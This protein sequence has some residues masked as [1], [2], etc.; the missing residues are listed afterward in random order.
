M[1]LE[2]E[3]K[4]VKAVRD[5]VSGKNALRLV[6]FLDVLLDWLETLYKDRRL[7]DE[8]KIFSSFPVQTLMFLERKN[9]AVSEDEYKVIKKKLLEESSQLVENVINTAEIRMVDFDL[10]QFNTAAIFRKEEITTMVEWARKHLGDIILRR[11]DEEVV[12]KRRKKEEQEAYFRKIRSMPDVELRRIV[13]KS[14]FDFSPKA[15]THKERISAIRNNREKM[16]KQKER[17]RRFERKLIDASVDAKKDAQTRMSRKVTQIRAKVEEKVVE[18]KKKSA[19]IVSEKGV[20]VKI[21]EARA[22]VLAEKK[23][24]EKNIMRVE[25]EWNTAQRSILREKEHITELISTKGKTWKDDFRKETEDAQKH[26]GLMRTHLVAEQEKVQKLIASRGS[27]ELGKAKDMVVGGKMRFERDVKKAQ[28]R[29]SGIAEKMSVARIDF[30]EKRGIAEQGFRKK[31]EVMESKIYDEMYK[32][33]RRFEKERDKVR[34]LFTEK[35]GEISSAAEEYI[36]E[37]KRKFTMDVESASK[38][39]LARAGEIGQYSWSGEGSRQLG[40][41]GTKAKEKIS[42]AHIR[43]TN[44]AISERDK[45]KKEIVRRKELFLL[46]VR[47]A[48]DKI[49]RQAREFADRIAEKREEFQERQQQVVARHKAHRKAMMIRNLLRTIRNIK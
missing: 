2:K 46:D 36:S 35:A 32:G 18:F 31:G 9:K 43:L 15:R 5:R 19:E 22:R 41:A 4:R 13:I 21:E 10:L 48:R 38:R 42:A 25:R 29:F 7:K 33:R 8:E 30:M 45:S 27:S 6:D 11:K 28:Q 12:R 24:L 20:Q 34:V 39:F 44:K 3:R 47:F 16:V 49:Q 14:L 23:N 40:S 26:I 37:K 17:F 1:V